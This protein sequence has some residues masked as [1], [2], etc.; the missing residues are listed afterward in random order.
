LITSATT[1][2]CQCPY[3]YYGVSC[4]INVCQTNPCV[5][6]TCIASGNYSYT[7]NCPVGFQYIMGVYVELNR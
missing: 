2:Q 3:S 4:Q 6:G 1:C 7:C 5:T